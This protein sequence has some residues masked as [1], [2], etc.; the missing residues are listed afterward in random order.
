M[1]LI[2]S[3]TIKSDFIKSK[4]WTCCLT[5]NIYLHKNCEINYR[6]NKKYCK[7]PQCQSIGTLSSLK[8]N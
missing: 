2:N 3:R 1:S 4:E 6:D 5:C 8:Y 7:Y